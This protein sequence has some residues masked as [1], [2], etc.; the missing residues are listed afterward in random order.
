MVNNQYTSLIISNNYHI[1]DFQYITTLYSDPWYPY[2]Y[3][4]PRGNLDKRCFTDQTKGIVICVPEVREGPLSSCSAGGYS[5]ND[6]HPPVLH[7]P[8]ELGATPAYPV[9]PHDGH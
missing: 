8:G 9:H 7:P 6:C 5:G 1:T 4:L 2:M 3:I